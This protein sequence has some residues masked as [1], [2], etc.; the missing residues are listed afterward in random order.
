MNKD[1]VSLEISK[2]IV[3]PIV[4]AKIQEAI[5]EALGGADEVIKKVT[6]TILTQKVDSKGQPSN[7]SYDSMSYLDYVVTNQIKEA[8]KEE[9]TKQII[10]SSSVIKDAIIKLVQTKNGA[11]MVAKALLDGM[12]KTFE[13]SWRSEIKINIKPKSDNE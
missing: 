8:I 4:T 2:D 9:L 12:N 7:Y 1:S 6:E 13:S 10:D 3:K 5:L 11:N